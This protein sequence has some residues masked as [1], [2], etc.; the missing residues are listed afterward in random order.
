VRRTRRAR[1]FMNGACISPSLIIRQ[2]DVM[3]ACLPSFPVPI[4]LRWTNPCA[5]LDT[6]CPA[7]RRYGPNARAAQPPP[8]PDDLVQ[9][10]P[11]DGAVALS[12]ADAPMATAW[13]AV[14]PS[15]QPFNVDSY[16]QAR[17]LGHIGGDRRSLPRETATAM[18]STRLVMNVLRRSSTAGK[19]QR[20]SCFLS[21][22]RRDLFPTETARVPSACHR[23]GYVE[24]S[25][26][27]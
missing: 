5:R 2:R 24:T 11:S 6:L 26:Q 25:R 22:R 21:A 14:P 23:H 3:A 8:R 4:L 19:E 9:E 1:R 12:F 17:R 27:T 7:L 10:Q 15:S 13:L 16:R 20:V 18:S